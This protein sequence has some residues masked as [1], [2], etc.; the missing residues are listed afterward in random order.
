MGVVTD[1]RTDICPCEARSAKLARFD[2][3]SKGGVGYIVISGLWRESWLVE[4]T[5]NGNLAV[6]QDGHQAEGDT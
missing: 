6:Q 3:L 1:G 4:L 5:Y 2:R